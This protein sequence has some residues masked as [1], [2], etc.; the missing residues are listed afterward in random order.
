[1]LPNAANFPSTQLFRKEDLFT[2][3]PTGGG[4]GGGATG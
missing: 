1:V 2:T 3:V 4:G